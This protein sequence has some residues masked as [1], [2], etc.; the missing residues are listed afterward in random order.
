MEKSTPPTILDVAKLADVSKA[1]VSYVLSGRRGGESRISDETRQRVLESVEELGYV[2]NQSARSLSRRRTDRVC[3][4]LPTLD[5]PYYMAL[6]QDI[7]GV[8]VNQDHMVVITVADSVEQEEYV[9]EHL[10]RR[11]ADGVVIVSPYELDEDKLASLVQAGIAVVVFSNHLAAKNFDVVRIT[12]DEALEQAVK[13]LVKQ[14]HRRF[15]IVG[16]VSQ[17]NIYERLQTYR[18]L[19]R[20]YGVAVDESLVEANISTREQAYQCT[21]ALL[22]LDNRPTAILSLTDRYAISAV[23]AARDAGMRIPHDVA[24]LGIGNIPEGEI[25]SP[26]LS[27]IG[28][29]SLDFCEIADLLFS[30]LKGK[31]S[32]AGRECEIPSQLILRGSA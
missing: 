19:L 3:I 13:H 11:L 24:I 26:P 1:T 25:I 17:L 8:A 22:G 10:R 20:D 31:A 14:G 21:Q 29:V 18:H 16:N 32:Q 9:F 30:R 12:E 27:T 15:A 7:Q 4:V 28:P 6:I 5:A 23:W 2:P